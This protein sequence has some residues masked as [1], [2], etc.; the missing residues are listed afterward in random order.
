MN[1]SL[2]VGIVK[3]L[4]IWGGERNFL[5]VGKEMKKE[6]RLAGSCILWN[7]RAGCQGK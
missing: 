3:I 5:L 1:N 4:R 7:I 2:L 6:M